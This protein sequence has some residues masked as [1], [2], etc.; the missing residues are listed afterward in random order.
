MSFNDE[1]LKEFEKT[2]QQ[3]A[4][5]EDAPRPELF[6]FSR[7]ARHVH[8]VEESIVRLHRHMAKNL[9]IPMPPNPETAYERWER[10]FDDQ[11]EDQLLGDI[12]RANPSALGL[13][14]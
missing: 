7:L 12:Y 3:I 11:Q 8:R 13:L 10:Q 9:A 5:G 1:L 6:G 4:E 2:F 14:N